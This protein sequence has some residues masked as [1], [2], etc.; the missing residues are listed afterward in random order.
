MKCPKCGYNSFEFN[1]TCKRCSQDLTGYKETYGLKPLVLP[2]EARSAMAA[3]LVTEPE[4]EAVPQQAPAP[5]ADMFSFELPETKPTPPPRAA[6]TDDMFTF[7]EPPAAT[8]PTDFGKFAL[9][10]E[11]STKQSKAVE[12]A[13]AD[14]LETTQLPGNDQ[15]AEQKNVSF[16]APDEYELSNF[17]WDDGDDSFETG[18]KGK[19][20]VDD[21]ESIFGETEGTTKK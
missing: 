11:T 6:G 2:P 8:P 15:N 18:T 19:K 7:S 16:G 17:S 1:D 13:F 4:P 20:P 21:F 10:D 12:D 3:A 5:P 14:L 9:D